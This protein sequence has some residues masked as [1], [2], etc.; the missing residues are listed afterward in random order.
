M[1]NIHISPQ[2][3]GTPGPP[4]Q[5]KARFSTAFIYAAL[6]FGQG[7]CMQVTILERSDLIGRLVLQGTTAGPHGVVPF[8]IPFQPVDE[9]ALKQFL[10]DGYYNS[11]A[12]QEL[13]QHLQLEHPE[14]WQPYVMKVKETTFQ[15]PNLFDILKKLLY[16]PDQIMQRLIA[17]YLK[18]DNDDDGNKIIT[19]G[20]IN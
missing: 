14:E 19:S 6:E 15:S 1:K 8:S 20:S 12:A 9:P 3:L 13:L 5:F 11:L 2:S 4:V 10:T 18:K 16:V 7:F 17:E